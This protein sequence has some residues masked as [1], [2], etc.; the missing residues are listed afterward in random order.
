MHVCSCMFLHA[1]RAPCI[2]VMLLCD[3]D[4]NVVGELNQN[5]I[6]IQLTFNHNPIRIQ[7]SSNHLQPASNHMYHAYHMYHMRS[8]FGL[9]HWALWENPCLGPKGPT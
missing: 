4:L 3:L 2:V 8:H 9:S 6:R 1:R 7:T 5:P